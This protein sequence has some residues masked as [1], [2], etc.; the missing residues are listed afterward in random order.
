M[1]T[2]WLCCSDYNTL[3]WKNIIVFFS[4]MVDAEHI[5][6]NVYIILLQ[7][8]TFSHI[9]MWYSAIIL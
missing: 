8:L 2:S 1:G 9:V 4:L 5:K 3:R 6:I 7:T